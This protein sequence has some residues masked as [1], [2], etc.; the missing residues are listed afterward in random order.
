VKEKLYLGIA[1]RI[2]M[3]FDHQKVDDH[4]SNFGWL[5]DEISAPQGKPVNRSY[6]TWEVTTKKQA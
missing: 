3:V 5:T 2:S 4:G 6:G 1:H